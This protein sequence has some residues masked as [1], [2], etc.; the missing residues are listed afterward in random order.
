MLKR[1]FDQTLIGYWLHRT[2]GVILPLVPPH[3]GYAFFGWLGALFFDVS[4]EMREPV[5]DNLRHVMRGASQKEIDRA[6]RNMLRIH[7]KNFFDF[8][9]LA[10]VPPDQIAKLVQVNGIDHLEKARARGKGVILISAHFGNHVVSGQAVSLCGYKVTA[11]AEHIKPEIL[12]KR[13][14]AMRSTDRLSIIPV[15]GPLLALVRALRKN[16]LLALTADLDATNSGI[17]VDFF[18]APAKLPDGHV[19]LALR[20]GAA[21]LPAFSLRLPDNTFVAYIEPAIGLQNTGN[22]QADVRAGVEQVLRVAEKWIG[23]YPEQWEMFHRVWRLEVGNEKLEF[24]TSN[25]QFPTS[26]THG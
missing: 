20:T 21:L 9:R 22:F 15:D 3:L 8:F 17:V 2:L 4:A 19:H 25:I 10:H 16:E 23:Q 7:L 5:R 14:V 11:V 1:I 26:R 24:L 18:G 6:G 13:V 12:F